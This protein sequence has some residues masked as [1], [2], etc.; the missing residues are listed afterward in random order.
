MKYIEF[1]EKFYMGRSKA[2]ITGYKSKEK[3]PEYI[4]KAGLPDEWHD[5]LPSSGS[6]YAKWMSRTASH[7]DP[8]SI[9]WSTI[10][11]HFEEDLFIDSLSRDLNGNDAILRQ[12]MFNFR[13]SIKP[14]DQPDKRLFAFALAKQFY[15]IAQ[16]NGEAEDVMKKFYNPNAHI[17]SFP[18]YQERAIEKY[19]K[20][21]LPFS[22]DEDDERELEDIYVCNKLSSR[23]GTGEKRRVARRSGA[24]VVTI[25]NATLADISGYDRHV[26]L[27]AIG[28]MG[29]S[30]M[31]Q[32]LFLDSIR[33]HT[34]KGL[35]PVLVELRNFSGE[36]DLFR[37]YIVKSVA[38]LDD[39][40]TEKRAEDLMTSGKCQILL[41]AADEIDQSDV[42]AFQQ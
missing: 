15:A 4:V 33:S 35:L 12:T 34:E 38:L 1:F 37:D 19:S 29:K 22:D 21:K 3:I 26:A 41:D 11:S 42:K 24:A 32:H 40:F 16:G 31:L 6:G 30:M 9:V 20:I 10:V 2:A 25:E 8:E 39:S 27:I 7:R 28:G 13:I 5:V 17:I 36:N 23:L 14:E 18:K